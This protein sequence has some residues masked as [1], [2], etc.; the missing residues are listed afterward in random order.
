MLLKGKGVI[1]VYIDFTFLC[2]YEWDYTT[3]RL[4][5]VSHDSVG[6]VLQYQNP[7]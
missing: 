2:V 1:F 4:I 5:V 7:K 3:K 6:G